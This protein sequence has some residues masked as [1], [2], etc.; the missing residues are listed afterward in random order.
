MFQ[1][2]YYYDSL[3][4]LH[5]QVMPL[6]FLLFR[7]M[8]MKIDLAVNTLPKALQKTSEFR[9]PWSANLGRP[10]LLNCR[11]KDVHRCPGTRQPLRKL[12]GPPNWNPSRGSLW[13]RGRKIIAALTLRRE[14]AFWWNSGT[15]PRRF[16]GS[17]P[18][19]LP[20]LRGDLLLRE[21]RISTRSL[22][23]VLTRLGAA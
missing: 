17:N 3:I 12:A 2:L 23:Q 18:D 9:S 1:V 16:T 19:G 6:L 4:C 8:K 20:R 7:L 21:P 5:V 15:H 22:T 14:T 11:Q 10:I 13:Q